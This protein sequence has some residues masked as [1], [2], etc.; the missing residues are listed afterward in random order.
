M[1][2]YRHVCVLTLLLTASAAAPA[3]DAMT[4]LND[5]AEAMHLQDVKTIRYTATGSAFAIGQSFRPG[6]PYPRSAAQVVRELDLEGF[7]ARQEFVNTRVDERGGGLPNRVGAEVRQLQFPNQNAAWPQHVWLWLNPAGF[8]TG[9]MKHNPV[10]TTERVD[11]KRYRVVAVKL[12]DRYTVRGLFNDRNLLNK[13]EAVLDI[14]PAIGDAP[15]DA[16]FTGYRDFGGILFPSR[17]THYV[18]YQPSFDFNITSVTPNVA[19]DTAPP[20][21]TPGTAPAAAPGGATNVTSQAVGRGVHYLMGGTYHSVMVEFAD[22]IVVIDAPLTEARSLAVIAEVKK[23]VPGKP[24][25]YI[26]NTHH[27]FD[28]SGGLRAY[29]DEGAAIITHPRNAAFYREWWSKPQ[30]LMRDRL[31]ESGKTARFETVRDRMVLSDGMQTM[32]IRV[33]RGTNHVEGMLI[34]YLPNEKL[35]VEADLYTPPA[36]GAAPVQGLPDNV[37]LAPD[38]VKNIERFRFDVQRILPLHGPGVA[39]RA[40]LDRAA[41]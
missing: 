22:Y 7:T 41:G 33:V 17:I 15:L 27:H 23:L 13:V 34:A 39:S 9:A 12:Q 29:V 36:P 11:G 38:L 24:I 32:E 10:L 1:T 5:A 20:A 14:N 30:V 31:A 25:R 16:V 26:V 37:S 19:V 2:R 40:D 4:V 3:Q 28:H 8:I 21:P 35:L 6:G 18:A